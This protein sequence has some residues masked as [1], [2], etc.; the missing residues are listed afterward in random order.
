MSLKYYCSWKKK[1]NKKP[2]NLYLCVIE[3][4]RLLE[5]VAVIVSVLMSKQVCQLRPSQRSGH[6]TQVS[7]YIGCCLVC[8]RHG[9]RVAAISWPFSLM[10][11]F[12]LADASWPLLW[13][14][15][16]LSWVCFTLTET[17]TPEIRTGCQI[18]PKVSVV[19]GVKAVTDTPSS[20]DTTPIYDKLVLSHDTFSQ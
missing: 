18:N 15:K 17:R 8:C 16:S 14:F 12:S 20:Y 5:V 7:L 3:F 1:K 13:V 9:R 11:F 6:V 2:H 19:G 10:S 4:V